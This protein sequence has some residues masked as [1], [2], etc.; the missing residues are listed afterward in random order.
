VIV[1][2]SREQVV[3]YL[4]V[5]HIVG[6]QKWDSYAKARYIASLFDSTHDIGQIESQIGDK[7]GAVRKSL[8]AYRM[9]RQLED[10]FEFNTAPAKRNFSLLL[11]SIGQ[12]QIKSYLGLPRSLAA[13]D[14]ICPVPAKKT[15]NLKKFVTWI[16][17]DGKQVPVIRESRDITQYLSHVV[18]SDEALDH[19]DRTGNLQEAFDRSD[20]EERMLLRYL[21]Q[22]NRKLES[23]L[24]VAHRHKTPDVKQEA[25]KCFATC[26]QLSHALR[27]DQDNDG[28]Q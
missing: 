28:D 10:E 23:A 3:P 1:Y 8:A 22:A 21:T 26:K 2:K 7:Q 13:L 12:G 27:G 24:G 11:L 17:G 5:R 25:K 15:E 18:G 16:L 4:G 14:L 9:L 20:G 6:I 19:L